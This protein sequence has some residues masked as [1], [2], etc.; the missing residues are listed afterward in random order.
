[1]VWP[2]IVLS[3]VRRWLSCH[4]Q[5]NIY[6]SC[7]LAV[8][9]FKAWFVFFPTRCQVQDG[10]VHFRQTDMLF[11]MFDFGN[12]ELCWKLIEKE[13]KWNCYTNFDFLPIWI[14]SYWSQDYQS[15][16]PPLLQPIWNFI[17]LVFSWFSSLSY[18]LYNAILSRITPSKP[19]LL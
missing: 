13:V 8:L 17:I 12:P 10:P 4:S 2:L 9:I 5:E 11:L 15:F 18:F 16:S 14:S 3:F 7:F 1:M 6:L 19:I